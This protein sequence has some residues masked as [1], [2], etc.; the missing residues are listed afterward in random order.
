MRPSIRPSVRLHKAL[1]ESHLSP[2]THTKHAG[3]RGFQGNKE[4]PFLDDGSG[5]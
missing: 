1:R 5:C 2:V 3:R 4:A